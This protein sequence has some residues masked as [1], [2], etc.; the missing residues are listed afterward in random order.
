M[1]KLYLIQGQRDLCGMGFP[2]ATSELAYQDQYGEVPI[3][4]QQV[5]K[6]P[7]IQED[8]GSIPGLTEWVKDL[9]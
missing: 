9:V 7:N 6:A 4:A 2:A 1:S 5:K 8:V 3:V